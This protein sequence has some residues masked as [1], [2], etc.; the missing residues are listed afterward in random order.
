M[1]V[2]LACYKP[3]SVLNKRKM[4]RGRSNNR[5]SNSTGVGSLPLD[6]IAGGISIYKFLLLFLWPKLISFYISV[7]N[8]KNTAIGLQVQTDRIL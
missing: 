5:G 1:H 4:E 6:V 3:K 8:Y 7:K 2:V